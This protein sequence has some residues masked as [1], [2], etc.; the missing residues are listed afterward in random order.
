MERRGNVVSSLSCLR[1]ETEPEE[2]M[3]NMR[4]VKHITCAV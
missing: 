2:Q 1:N 4:L 3:E